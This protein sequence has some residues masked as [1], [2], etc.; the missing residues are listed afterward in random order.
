MA[1]LIPLLAYGPGLPLPPLPLGEIS[2]LPTAFGSSVALVLGILLM[3]LVAHRR[4][5]LA[6]TRSGRG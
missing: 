5:G 2:G 6:L 3:V 1:S 4:F